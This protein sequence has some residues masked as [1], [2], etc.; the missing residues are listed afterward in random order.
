MSDCVK[1]RWRITALALAARALVVGWAW[2]RIPPVADGAFYHRVAERIAAGDGYTWLWDDGAVTYAA[3]YPVGYPALISAPYAVVG[4]HPG[5]AM[6]FNA[7][8]G[9]AA[10][11]AVHH[12]LS[13]RGRKTALF[14]A[15]AVAL[16]PGLVAYTPAL[17]TEGITAALWVCAVAVA[18][19]AT[20]AA[21]GRRWAL[22]VGCGVL[23]GVSTLVRPQ[24]VLFAPLLGAAVWPQA[25]LSRRAVAAAVLT[26]VTVLFCL[27]WTARNCARMGRCAFVSVNG[28]WN[29]LIG[30]QPEGRGAWSEIQVP[31]RCKTVFDEA[32]KDACFGEA[33]RERI[34]AA[35]A[36][37]LALLPNK[38]SVTFDYCGAGAWYLHQ[39]NGAAFSER[40]KA[41]IG[42]L[43]T[44]FE[45][46]VLLIALGGAWVVSSKRRGSVL[47]TVLLGIGL[48]FVVQE[49]ATPAYLSLAALLS[50]RD[51]R[52]LLD[53]ATAVAIALLALVHGVFFGAGRYQLVLWPLLC[54]AAALHAGALFERARREV[55]AHVSSPS[56]TR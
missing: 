10:C 26:L 56:R 27:P 40:A 35:P 6:M 8:I 21:A 37:W 52:E 15:L 29:L 18:Q 30:T 51:D 11:W 34:R 23:L 39:A 24:S 50:W 46:L 47:R 44:V 49:H 36:E 2:S 4:A 9:A 41:V 19:R 13:S 28:G 25:T 31:E 20:K 12:L 55:K 17:M 22:L 1:D 3:H 54:G 14:G 43:E 7:V 42:A 53:V 32:G 5:V 48:V 33:A 45:R 38:L 16:H